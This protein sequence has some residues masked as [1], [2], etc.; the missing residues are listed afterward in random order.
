MSIDPAFLS[1]LEHRT[2]ELAFDMDPA[3]LP[4]GAFV[5]YKHH[6][7]PSASLF[8]RSRLKKW[9]R[10]LPPQEVQD[11]L[12]LYIAY[13]G[14]M[15]FGIDSGRPEHLG[16]SGL[17]FLPLIQWKQ[18]TGV[19]KQIPFFRGNGFP[20]GPWLVFGMSA[21]EHT[22]LLVYTGEETPR[23][24]R[25][26]RIYMVSAEAMDPLATGAIAEGIGDLLNQF[27]DDPLS[28]LDRLNFT[29]KLPDPEGTL[30]PHAPINYRHTPRR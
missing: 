29:L 20:R 11:W 12:N 23:G 9:L 17:T 16:L 5:P 1:L 21:W 4:D 7:G 13:D 26:G 15:F 2:G 24:A 19:L 28:F 22:L 25:T 30:H 10:G 27:G 8:A 6:V 3:R 14:L 18:G